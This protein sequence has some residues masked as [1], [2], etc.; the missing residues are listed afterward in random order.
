MSYNRCFYLFQNR[1]LLI[2]VILFLGSGCV[3]QKVNNT[4]LHKEPIGGDEAELQQR[5]LKYIELMHR[6][7]PGTNWREIEIANRKNLLDLKE[8]KIIERSNHMRMTQESFAGGLVTGSWKERGSRNIAGNVQYMDY[9]PTTN[10]I[11]LVSNGGTLWKGNA[12]QGNWQVLNQNKQFNPEIIKLTVNNGGARRII[13]SADNQ[14]LYSD[15]DGLS[16]TAAT[17]LNFPISWGGN[18]LKTVEVLND[19]AQ[20]IYCLARLWDPTPWSPRYWLYR[21]TDH[22]QTYSVVHKFDFGSDNQLS[23]FSPLNSTQLVALDVN[24]TANQSTLYNISGSTVTVLNNSSQLPVNGK[25]VLKGFKATSTTTYY[26]LI[27]NNQVYKSINNGL[28]W[29]LQSDLPEDAWD[30]LEVSVSDAST[31]YT[32]GVNAYRSTNGGASWSLVTGGWTAY[33]SNPSAKLHADM[34]QIQSFRKSDNTEFTAVNCHGGYYISYDK[35]VTVSNKSLL[36][37]NTA[38]LW[39]HI[40]DRNNND[41]IYIGSQDQGIQIGRGAN[42]AGTMDFYQFYSGDYGHLAM[43]DNPSRLWIEY[44]GGD[45]TFYRQPSTINSFNGGD[46]NMMVD[47]TQKPNAGWML[48]TA[49]TNNLSANE[50]LVGGGNMTGGAGSY[51]IKLKAS[52]SSNTIVDSQYNYNFLANSNNGTSCISAIEASVISNKYFVATEDGTFFYSNDRGVN[53]NKTTSFLGPGGYWLYG[54]CILASQNNINRLWLAGSGYS[55]PGV[56]KSTDGG[57]TFA[58]M[59]NGLPSTLVHEIVATPDEQ[60]LFAATEAGP[61]MYISATDQWYS[62]MSADIPIVDYFSVEYIAEKNTV[63]FGTYGRG[64]WD[65]VIESTQ[66]DQYIC[67]GTGVVYT[68]DQI[69]LLY[70]WQ[71]NSGNGF[72][73]INNN[74]IYSGAT[75]QQLKIRYIPSSFGGYEY[76]CA[77]GGLFSSVYTLKLTNYWK[78][79]ISTEWEN[80]L[81]WNCGV[82]PDG[83]TDVIIKNSAPNLPEINSNVSCRSINVLPGR[84]LKINTGGTLNVTH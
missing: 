58:A 40:T 68:S 73:N 80:P 35:L 22:G 29:T 2:G 18:Y 24:S 13:A 46:G 8:Q 45:I 43:T 42:T 28:N 77:V 33:Y 64:I 61:Y 59:N 48:P 5:R 53:W 23:L 50:L 66:L 70:Q 38:Q 10:E 75:T 11:Y 47:G 72:V 15:N 56:Y 7:A 36:N 30:R 65:F 34:M 26:C 57:Q 82:V 54:S 44:P 62:L 31:L 21:S 19:A 78:G 51:L 49:N 76:R 17:G 14:L 71:V 12:E 20:T 83:N 39:D 27:N 74:G 84:A 6:S 69:G 37:L 55:N 32:G 3:R 41:I 1:L 67:P 63:R 60:M 79:T 16:F 9:A 81:N 52:L 4:F 25:C